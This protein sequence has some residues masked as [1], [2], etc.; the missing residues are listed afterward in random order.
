MFKLTRHGLFVCF[1]ALTFAMVLLG[2]SC[3]P[4]DDGSPQISTLTIT[5]STISESSTGMTDQFFEIT[6]VTANFT[7][8]IE[9]AQVF[10]QDLNREAVFNTAP[11]I[12]GDTIVIKRV[13]FAWFSEVG[14]GEHAISATVFSEGDL[15]SATELNLT[16][17]TVTP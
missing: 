13:P 7:E 17:V 4:I 6:I 1:S 14:V 2:S 12:T 11:E 9:S 15:Q 5:P 8:P 16:T 10:I 3:V